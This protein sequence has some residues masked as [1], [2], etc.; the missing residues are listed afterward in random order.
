VM[1]FDFAEGDKPGQY[2]YEVYL[3]GGAEEFGIALFNPEDYRFVGFLDAITNVK[4]GLIHKDIPVEQLPRDGK[5]LVKVFAK[6]AGK[7]DFIEGMIV[8]ENKQD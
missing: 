3:P 1:G 2:S 8:I 5:Y 4:K 7:E 6:K